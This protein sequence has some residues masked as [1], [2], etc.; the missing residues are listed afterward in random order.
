MYIKI[1]RRLFQQ[2]PAIRFSRVFGHPQ[3]VWRDVW[4][5]Y[6]ILDYSEEEAREYLMLLIKRNIKRNQ[7]KLWIKRTEAY[8][9]A[10]IAIR[11]GAKEV[12]SDY[13]G[14]VKGFVERELNRNYKTLHKSYE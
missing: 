13:F 5:R 12:K 6:K 2:D 1:Q 8:N 11:K 3:Q 7:F 10:Q 4:K 9:R 14:P